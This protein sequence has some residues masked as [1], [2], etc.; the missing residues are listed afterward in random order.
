MRKFLS[1]LSG[2]VMGALVGATVAL[3]LAP[4]SGDELRGQLQQRL[5]TLRDELSEAASS[6]KIE[7][8]KQLKTMRQSPSSIPVEDA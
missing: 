4:F 5:N 6:R 2:A 1:F 3:L 7:L 8:E